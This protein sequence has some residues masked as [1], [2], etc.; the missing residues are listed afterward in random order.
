MLEFMTER[1]HKAKKEYVC[2]ICG[3][4]IHKGEPYYR[5]AA[6]YEGKMLD[7]CHH[8][9]CRNMSVEYCNEQGESEYDT[10]SIT[11]Y[12][13]EKYCNECKHGYSHEL[14][15]GYEECDFSIFECPKLLKRF[16][17]KEETSNGSE[18]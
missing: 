9:H 16:S 8:I 10:D 14:D 1:M 3:W 7:Y 2:D 5:Y 12:I 18:S 13:Q 11:E 4:A 15:E 17:N 6:K